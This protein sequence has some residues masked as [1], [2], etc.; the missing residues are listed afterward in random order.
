MKKP[1]DTTPGPRV[2]GEVESDERDGPRILVVDDNDDLRASARAILEGEG[3]SLVEAQNGR[4]ALDYL[5][6]TPTAPSLILLDMNMPTMS[7]AD[8]ISVL[9]SYSR[10]V[11]IP[12]VVVTSSVLPEDCPTRGTVGRLEKPY[13][14]RDLIAMVRRH[15]R[16]RSD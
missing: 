7:G 13:S 1:A 11:A 12:V 4:A 10:F 15:I 8:T 16:T 5:F 6:A 9:Q 2:A 3:Y 14:A